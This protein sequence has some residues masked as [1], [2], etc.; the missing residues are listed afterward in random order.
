MP[1]KVRGRPD[2]CKRSGPGPGHASF[3][4]W[5]CVRKS[6]GSSSR[7]LACDLLF[8]SFAV[9]R[10]ACDKPSSGVRKVCATDLH[11]T[12]RNRTNLAAAKIQ[13]VESIEVRGLAK[14]RHHTQNSPVL[15]TLGV[16]LPLPAPRFPKRLF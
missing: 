11:R 9:R 1:T 5:K 13:V 2:I 12:D 14:M 7:F 6:G 4:A 16:Q 10:S 8:P 3:S 15:S